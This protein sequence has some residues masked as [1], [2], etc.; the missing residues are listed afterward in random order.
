MGVAVVCHGDRDRGGARPAHVARQGYRLVPRQVARV[1]GQ[2]RHVVAVLERAVGQGALRRRGEIGYVLLCRRPQAQ[3]AA[4]RGRVRHVV[5]VVDSQ[6]RTRH[7]GIGRK[8]LA[9]VVHLHHRVHG[10]KVQRTGH[11]G[12]AV[13]IEARIAALLP[14]VAVV[15]AVERSQG[16]VPG[17]AGCGRAGGRGRR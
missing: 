5:E 6:Q 14:Q 12:V 9:A 8:P 13:V 15:E 7:R 11:Q 4:G 10:V 16:R 1:V 17:R 2:H 3:V